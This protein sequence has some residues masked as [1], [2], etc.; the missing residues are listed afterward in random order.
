MDINKIVNEGLYKTFV[1]FNKDNN[2]LH[3]LINYCK[4]L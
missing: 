1:G 3:A 4:N 2:N